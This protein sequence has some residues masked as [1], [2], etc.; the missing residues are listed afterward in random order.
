MEQ[1]GRR[2]VPPAL[3]HRDFRLFWLGQA[4]SVMGTQFTNVGMAWQIY[5]LTDSVLQI[6]LLGLARAIPQMILT[7]FGGILAD[8]LD[9]RRMLIGTQLTQFAVAAG[10]VGFTVT[11]AMSPTVLYVAS[12]LLA[13]FG[14][15]ENPARQ[16]Y[17]PNLVPREDLTSAIALT[18]SM[19]Q[20]GYVSGPALGGL[21]LA[22]AGPASCYGMD[23]AARALMSGL[24]L[25]IRMRQI[26]G[27]RGRITLASFL[28]GLAFVRSQPIILSLMVLDFGAN[29]FGSPRALLPVYARDI[30]QVGPEGLGILFAA[31]SIGGLAG[32][33]TMSMITQPRNAG[34]WVLLG[35]TFYAF[36][37]MAFA[38]S[39]TFWVAAAM[40]LCMGVGDNVSSVLRGSINQLVTPDDLRGRVSA[41]NSIFVN[42]G[43]QLGQFESG[44]VAAWTSVPVAAFT[45]GLATLLLV[46][47]VAAVPAVRRFNLPRGAPEPASA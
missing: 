17:A 36:A 45:G 34:R 15:L 29:F 38:V 47:G 5:E 3:R 37:A 10:L 4:V 16:A 44:V 23:A 26:A 2:H 14:A 41:V 40:L 32:S 31:S 6:G 21:A 7:L 42:V 27:R 11:G 1:S 24:L 12:A 43:P 39:P 25:M 46:L 18:T 28:E 13:I 30:F 9:R 20:V 19:R 8:A 22:A 33:I 35:V